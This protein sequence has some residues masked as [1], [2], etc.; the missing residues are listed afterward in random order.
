M[1]ADIRDVYI[2]IK[3]LLMEKPFYGVFLSMLNKEFTTSID[4]A[5][6]QFTNDGKVTLLINPDFWNDLNTPQKKWLLEHEILHI[7]YKHDLLSREFNNK[8]LFNIAADM[9][10]NQYL[11]YGDRILDSVD[12]NDNKYSE[13]PIKAGTKKYY[14]LLKEIDDPGEAD[15]HK[16]SDNI[17]NSFLNSQ[18]E[19]LVQK[20]VKDSKEKSIGSIP[21]KALE[22]VNEIER[23]KNKINWRVEIKR[24]GNSKV[25]SH[26]KPTKYRES[27]RYSGLPGLKRKRTKN[28]LVAIDTSGSVSSKELEAFLVEINGL[29][30]SNVQITIIQVDTEISDICHIKK[31]VINEFEIKGRGGTSFQPAIDYYQDNFRE[32]N[33]LI[34]FTDG[35]ASVPNSHTNNILWVFTNKIDNYDKFPGRKLFIDL[36]DD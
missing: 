17:S 22:L 33:G 24:Y 4:R 14:Q 11:N 25:S 3:Q 1:L 34:Y 13:F 30:R 6:V 21:G 29:L 15:D 16:W 20:S 5:C 19:Y 2:C 31:S 18:I 7:V 36:S 9:E 32:Y 10:I 27:R 35:Y 8:N 26:I 12:I 23:K 28:I